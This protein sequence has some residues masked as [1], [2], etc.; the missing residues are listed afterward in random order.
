MKGA[1]QGALVLHLFMQLSIH[2]SAQNDSVEGEI[3]EVIYAALEG[4]SKIS[5]R[6]T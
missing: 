4:S 3:E 5:L 1:L 2:K 6:S